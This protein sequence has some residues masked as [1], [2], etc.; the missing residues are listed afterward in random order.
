[1]GM[2]ADPIHDESGLDDV[3][4]VLKKERQN[5]ADGMRSSSELIFII[6]KYKTI[7]NTRCM[8]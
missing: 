6:R 3:K 4:M 7:Y 8:G 2:S 5:V 1:M